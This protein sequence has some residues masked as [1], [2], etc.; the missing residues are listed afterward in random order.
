MYEFAYVFHITGIAVWIGS[1]IGFAVLMRSVASKGEIHKTEAGIIRKIVRF[2]NTGVLPA[3]GIVLVSGVYMILQFNR[4]T[5]PLYL[6]LMEQAGSMAVLFTMLGV[7]LYSRRVT[8]KLEEDGAAA[9][10]GTYSVLLMLSA[11]LALIVVII[12]GLR[13]V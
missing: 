4:E 8:K 7:G 2:V 3:S 13:L 10:A 11:G 12:T 6:S 5:L 9:A 1:F